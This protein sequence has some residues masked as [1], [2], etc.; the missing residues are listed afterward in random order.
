MRGTNG[1]NLELILNGLPCCE[2]QCQL[3]IDLNQIG[4]EN[5]FIKRSLS[6]VKR[7]NLGDC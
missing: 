6:P 3:S 7:T 4:K 2:P 1:C 5:K